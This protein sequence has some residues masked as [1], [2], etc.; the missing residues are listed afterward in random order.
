[1]PGVA[2]DEF[3]GGNLFYSPNSGFLYAAYWNDA[4]SRI[5]V[6][7]RGNAFVKVAQPFSGKTMKG[8]P[9]LVRSSGAPVLIAPDSAGTFW[10]TQFDE[11]ALT[12][13][14]P[15]QVAT[16][17]KWQE[18]V[19]LRNGKT[20]RQI[21]Y[22]ADWVSGGAFPPYL[23]FFYAKPR[24]AAGFTQ[25]QGVTC[26]TAPSFSCTTN[27]GFVTPAN[28]NALLPATAVFHS[29]NQGG[30]VIRPY[31]SYWTDLGSAAGTLALRVASAGN[32]SL[33]TK[34]TTGS[35]TPCVVS[36]YWGDYDQMVIQEEGLAS[37][38]LIRAGTDSTGAACT[39]N[40][41]PQHVS[42]FSVV[43]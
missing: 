28:E 35:Q 43:P 3:D 19:Q 1:M 32:L 41:D 13:S 38:R 34:A 40:G 22:A 36:D 37:A 21:G 4:R 42:T 33:V 23:M 10:Y 9:L 31:L 18:R 14:A 30:P 26:T 16:G 24:S 20:L 5:D 11:T 25:L 2:G 39:A 29:S 27:A 12:W 7:R 6:F 15:V 17:F 8:H